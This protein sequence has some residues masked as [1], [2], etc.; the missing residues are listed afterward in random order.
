MIKGKDDMFWKDSFKSLAITVGFNTIIALFITGMGF[1]DTLGVNFIF[2]QC[3]G[4]SI[5]GCVS[6]VYRLFSTDRPFIH[7]FIV[8]IAMI[9]AISIGSTLAVF[10]TG[11]DPGVFLEK[12]SFFIQGLL[13]ALKNLGRIR[14]RPPGYSKIKL[15]EKDEKEKNNSLF[16]KRC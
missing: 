12:S 4:L 10:L 11:I 3:I 8:I 9:V 13:A 2:A 5:C 16:L 15:L 1:G 6:S 14:G 7:F